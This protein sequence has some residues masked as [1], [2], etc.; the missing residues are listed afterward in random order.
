M[1]NKDGKVN[2]Y[3]SIYIYRAKIFTTILLSAVFL[4]E[5]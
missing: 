1:K 3:T 2:K 4:E 5:I